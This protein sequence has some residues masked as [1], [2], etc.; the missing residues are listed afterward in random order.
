VKLSAILEPLIAAGVPGD[1]ILATVRAFENQNDGAKEKSKEKARERWRR[2]KNKQDTNVGKRLQTDA[3]VSKQ[4]V[5]DRDARVEDNLQTKNI[6]GQEEKK[7]P[8]PPARSARGSRIPDDFKPDI[9][10]AVSEGLP[11]HEAE[12]QALSFCDFWRAKPGKDA[13]KLD[14]PA[15]WRMWFRRRLDEKPQARA[16]P[17]S[18]KRNYADVAADRWSGGNGSEG[19]FGGDGNVEFLPPRKQQPGPDDGHLRGGLARRFITGNH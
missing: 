14:W 6:T 2:W 11:R 1:V 4:L 10:A 8:S 19:V 15:T 12:R 7:E 5:R 9:E 16:G 3:N 18:R 13:M 17:P